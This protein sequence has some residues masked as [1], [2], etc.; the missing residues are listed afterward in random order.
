MKQ[1]LVSKLLQIIG[2]ERRPE[3][4]PAVT[5]DSDALRVLAH[6]LAQDGG[7]SRLLACDSSGLLKIV[8]YAADGN[9]VM[10][11]P[12][13]YLPVT[14]RGGTYYPIGLSADKDAHVMTYEERTG[15]GSAFVAVS[16]GTLGT[17]DLGAGTPPAI[18]EIVQDKGACKVYAS[19]TAGA[20]TLLLG[21]CGQ[22]APNKFLVSARYVDVECT[23]TY[24]DWSI[25]ARWWGV[26]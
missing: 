8:P 24:G 10:A 17:V 2:M 1:T 25:I 14:V 20:K 7:G 23:G 12:G 4:T 22:Y 9:P 3:W 15:D 19:A 13:S 5:V 21:G 11:T 6:L 18:V 16:A 26:T